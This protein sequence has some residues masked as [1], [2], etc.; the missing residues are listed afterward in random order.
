MSSHSENSPQLS[1]RISGG[2]RTRV[3]NFQQKNNS[4]EDGIAR[5]NGYFRRNSG[6]PAEQTTLRIPFQTLPRK[7]KQ[8]RI[9]FRGTKIEETLG[10]T[11]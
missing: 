10:I 4:T 3:G 2:L 6:C 9:L 5:T 11:F 1:R 8:L 7:R